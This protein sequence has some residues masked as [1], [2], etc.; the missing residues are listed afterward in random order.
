LARRDLA[1][2]LERLGKLAAAKGDKT[3]AR[4]YWEEEL[5][6]AEALAS[7][8]P[9]NADW[10]RFIAAVRLMIADLE[11]DDAQGQTRKA[12]DLL[13]GLVNSGRLAPRDQAMFDALKDELGE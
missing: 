9:T 3:I 10:P 7:S 4:T 2:G 6:I 5:G 13:I 11:E 12:F 8:D 1:I